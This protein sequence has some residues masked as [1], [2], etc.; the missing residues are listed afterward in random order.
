M[1]HR[2]SVKESCR[3]RVREAW[4]H[5]DDC[6]SVPVVFV[7]VRKVRGDGVSE[8][9]VLG[10]SVESSQRVA[11]AACSG[12]RRGCE[13]AQQSP[14]AVRRYDDAA[15]RHG[16]ESVSSGEQLQE[17]LGIG[18]R[19]LCEVQ[20]VNRASQRQVDDDRRR[21][22]EIGD[23]A[24][25]RNLDAQQ[26]RKAARMRS[27]RNG[28]SGLDIKQMSIVDQGDDRFVSRSLCAAPQIGCTRV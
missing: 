18:R 27:L 7:K 11:S 15:A 4:Q 5:S 24:G 16:V 13:F 9:S 1:I 8:A 26:S 3:I 14:G 10:C 12:G 22:S 20:T 28:D 2:A 25:T 6:Q 19:H 17:S 21:W 23:P